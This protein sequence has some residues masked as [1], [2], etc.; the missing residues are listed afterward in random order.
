MDI[1][2]LFLGLA[3]L[4]VIAFVVARPL[5]ERPNVS[6]EP[7]RPAER[8]LADRE[9]VLT[10]MRDLDF[11]R[12]MSKINEVDF[13]AQRAQLVAE[14]V[15]ILKQLDALGLTP[16]QASGAP[17]ARLAPSGE[18]EAAVAQVRARRAARAPVDLDAEIEAGV[19]AAAAARRAARLSGADKIVCAKCGAEPVP[20]DRFCARCGAPL[21][22]AAGM[23]Q[24]KV[25]S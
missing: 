8:L 14:G 23:R 7:L 18:I 16:G 3:L 2:S 12:A 13:T 20:G 22:A 21:P 10:Q 11:D 19:A 17:E 1:G 5:I 4:V 9:R 25:Q 24:A 6:D 15:A